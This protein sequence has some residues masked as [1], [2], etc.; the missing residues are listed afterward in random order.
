MFIHDDQRAYMSKNVKLFDVLVAGEINPDFI[1]SDPDLMPEFGQ[2][3]TLV[4]DAQ[5]TIGSSS[6]IYACGAARLGLKVAFVGVVG[7][8]LFGS[9]IIDALQERG[10]D[11]SAVIVDPEIKTGVSVIL[12]RGGDRAIL[13][14]LGTI[15]ALCANKISEELLQSSRHLHV[16]SYFL[17]DNLRPD[18]PE[19]FAR[20]KSLGLTTSLDTNWDPKGEW[21]GLE[22]VLSK[23]DV[24]MPNEQELIA[25]SRKPLFDEA[26]QYM[27]TQ[28]P[29]IAVKMGASGARAIRGGEV[30]HV[31]SLHITNIADQIGAGDTFDAGFT[32]GFLQDWDLHRTMKLAVA[33]GSLSLREHGGTAAQP[34][35]KEALKAADIE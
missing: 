1:L 18:L 27:S 26:L 23:V 28:V 10:V 14:Y 16:A 21:I 25:I 15:A 32:Y 24:F 29:L 7:H 4:S 3:E 12:N 2:V 33:C 20:A 22:K 6:A 30:T 19:L 13:T 9:F 5:L 35:L 8:D 11:T 17:Q 34:T 31:D